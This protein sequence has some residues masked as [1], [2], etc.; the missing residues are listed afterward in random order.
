MSV[1]HSLKALKKEFARWRAQKKSVRSPVPIQLRRKVLALRSQIDDTTLYNT[2]DLRPAM[3]ES[4]SKKENCTSQQVDESIEFVSIPSELI[5]NA[6]DSTTTHATAS[7][8]SVQLSCESTDG[9]RWCLQGSLSPEQFSAFVQA[10]RIISG[11]A[12]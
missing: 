2:L 5:D 11:G 7:T 10:I 12:Q 1:S 4:W 8:P 3:V 6:V 9:N